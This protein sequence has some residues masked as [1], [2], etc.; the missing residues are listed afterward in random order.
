MPATRAPLALRTHL[1]LVVAGLSVAFV[2][3][4][5]WAEVDSTRRGVK[6]EIDAANR[7]A[8]QLLQR[9]AW[10]YARTGGTALAGF[11]QQL[12]RV[13][14]NKIT[15]YSA[16]G[17][18]LYAS[19]PSPYKAGRDA[20]AWFA[21]LIMPQPPMPQSFLLEG[22][23]RLM[24]E[25]DPSRAI[26]DGWDDLLRILLIG[27]L[28]IAFVNAL[29]FYFVGRA[30]RPFPVIADGLR[31]LERGELG[32]RLAPL[33]GREAGQIGAAFNRMAQA[34][35][36]K[37]AVERQARE[38]EARLEERRELA[39]IVDARIE[40]ERRAIAHEL[41][42]EFGQSVTA[43]RSLAVAIAGQAPES[44]EKTRQ[45]A[46]LISD[47]AAR[48]YDAMHGLIPRL[49]PLSLDTLGLAD[50]LE[51]LVKDWQRRNPTVKLALVHELP[52]ELGASAALAIYRVAQEGLV[53]AVRHARASRID[54]TVL[55]SEARVGVTVVDDGI[56]LASDWARPGHFGL[57]GLSE[58]IAR[59]HG[60]FSIANAS[61][62]GVRL[63]AEIPLEGRA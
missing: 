32:F 26:L 9:V 41:H 5:L 3:A 4:L 58:R 14:S 37:V 2:A 54:V 7:V 19:P 35:Q 50:T 15:L 27:G 8:A 34:V 52:V 16:A 49:T 59:L 10:T 61:P 57:R 18:V 56:G 40:E 31:R 25:A 63:H 33:Q 36:D 48:L 55:A 11:L 28:A 20:P 43:I 51:N 17:E 23:G 46:R 45:A 24:V 6:E 22:G 12:G 39:R 62:R 42:D 30:L 29:A 44:D 53:N 38:T 21:R 13:R 1:N 47:E 60:S